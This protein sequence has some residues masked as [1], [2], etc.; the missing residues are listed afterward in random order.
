MSRKPT[1]RSTN[2]NSTS[3]RRDKTK[4]GN[5]VIPLGDLR[6]Q[7]KEGVQKHKHAFSTRR[8]YDSCVK[9]M[10]KWA[11]L[12]S[13][14]DMEDDTDPP[15]PEFADAFTGAPNRCSPDALT[16]YLTYKC[17]EGDNGKST[18]E[19]AYSAMKKY[20]EEM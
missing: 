15:D 3:A 11:A 14:S 10:Q 20:W 18:A 5:V 8:N 7:K 13:S 12:Y 6:R 4:S 1:I 16:L 19:G 2:T 17:I 9:R